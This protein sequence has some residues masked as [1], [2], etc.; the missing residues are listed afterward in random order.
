[1]HIRLAVVGHT[2][3]PSTQEGSGRLISEFK[4]S[5]VYRVSSGTARVTQRNTV[6]KKKKKHIKFKNKNKKYTSL[7]PALGRQRQADF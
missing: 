4:A 3:N 6:L 5:L 2:F 1:M 7:I